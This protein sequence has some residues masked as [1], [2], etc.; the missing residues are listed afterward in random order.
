VA[1]AGSGASRRNAADL[2]L[3][4]VA[5]AGAG[6]PD[7]EALLLAGSPIGGAPDADPVDPVSDSDAGTRGQ[8]I[9]VW[10]PAGAPGRTTLAISI[11]SEL[12]A[13][14]FSVVLADADT[15]SGSVAPALGLL[16]E[17]P[18]FAAA[19]RLAATDSLTALELER[20]GQRYL[21]PHG[22]FWVLTGIGRPS[23]WPELSAERVV[24]VV[25]ACRS[26]VDF[27][28]LDTGFSLENDEEISSD[29]FAPRRNAATIS[30]LREADR[31]IAVGSADPVGL[32]RF[33][34]AH[35]DLVDLVEVERVTVVMNKIRASA[36]GLNPSGQVEQ[37]LQRFGG[38]T[39]PVL[40]PHDQASLDA[41]ILGGK[42]LRDVAGKSPAR[43]AMS[44]LV[45][46]RILPRKP[47]APTGRAQRRLAEPVR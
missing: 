29:L 44:R 4:E 23:R 11:A 25:A 32:S 5:D 39:G 22:S 19:C 45:S 14:G 28:V 20:V 21:S 9:A 33:L 17:A 35:V 46:T 1:V 10:G 40:I 41:A 8:V 36:I 47:D 31:V 30:A 15:H 6:W 27:T 34:R 37:T 3:R 13:E 38:I 42:T 12:A 26:W 2:G 43:L 24:T 16:D 7:I 18:G